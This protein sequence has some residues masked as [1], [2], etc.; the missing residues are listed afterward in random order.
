MKA[1]KERCACPVPE[2]SRCPCFAHPGSMPSLQSPQHQ[3]I[4]HNTNYLRIK[5]RFTVE[6]TQDTYFVVG[7]LQTGVILQ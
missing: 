5:K 2:F 4:S 6:V 7:V 1:G 3:M